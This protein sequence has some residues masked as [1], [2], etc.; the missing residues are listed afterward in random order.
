MP[1]TTTTRV[2]VLPSTSDVILDGRSIGHIAHPTP[3]S[4]RYVGY[5]HAPNLKDTRAEVCDTL[6]AAVAFVVA[7][8]EEAGR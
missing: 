5:W 2:E 8:A 6:G 1:T 3:G 4:P 7:C